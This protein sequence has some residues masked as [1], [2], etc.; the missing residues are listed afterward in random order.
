MACNSFWKGSALA[1]DLSVQRA[2]DRNG[3]DVS[4]NKIKFLKCIHHIIVV[5]FGFLSL[6]NKKSGIQ[7]AEV[8]KWWLESMFS[9]LRRI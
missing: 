1:K 7:K 4:A 9:I 5:G 3:L 6:V 2:E 8:I